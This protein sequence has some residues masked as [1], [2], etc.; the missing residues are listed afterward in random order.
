MKLKRNQKRAKT[1]DQIFNLE[2]LALRRKFDEAVIED[3]QDVAYEYLDEQ[4]YAHYKDLLKRL[5]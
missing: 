3:I 1:Y 4:E 2:N 5:Y